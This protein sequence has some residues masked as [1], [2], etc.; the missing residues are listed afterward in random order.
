MFVGLAAVVA[1]VVGACS[2]P[3]AAPPRGPTAAWPPVGVLR[4]RTGNPPRS[5]IAIS[6]VR[7]QTVRVLTGASRGGSVVP[8]S[9]PAWSPDGRSIAFSGARPGRR[10]GEA[11]SAVDIYTM[12]AAGGSVRRLTRVGDGA[13]PLWSP[14]GRFVIFTRSTFVRGRLHA[15]LWRVA[16]TGRKLAQLTRSVSG[17]ETAESFSPRSGELAIT[18]GRCAAAKNGGCFSLRFAIY[19]AGPDGSHQHLLLDGALSPAF[20]PTGSQIAYVT[21]HDKN[22]RLSY[23][24]QEFNAYELYVMSTDGTH[25]SRL[26]QTRGLNEMAPSWSPDGGQIAFQRGQTTGNAEG[27]SVLKVNADGSCPRTI[28]GDPQLN[29]WYAA[30]EWRPGKQHAGDGRL[31]C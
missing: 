12:A 22:G 17:T 3:A 18:R 15:S 25:R 4:I 8:K 14:D 9:G 24:D 20:S 27:T 19:L 11:A 1:L 21:D 28:L 13:D 10:R 16:A 2:Q 6:D 29:T 23:G 26:T 30:P 31:R 7:G 5:D